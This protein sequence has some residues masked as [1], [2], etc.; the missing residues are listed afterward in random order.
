MLEPAYSR[1]TRNILFAP[2]GNQ[3]T[4]GVGVVTNEGFNFK[5]INN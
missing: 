5:G 3:L 1:L 2:P 4:K